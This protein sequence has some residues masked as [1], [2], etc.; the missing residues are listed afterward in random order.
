[1]AQ[2]RVLI[3]DPLTDRRR[4]LSRILTDLHYEVLEA[5]DG[6][7]G[8]KATETGNPDLIFCDN[9]IQ[10][11]SATEL[12]EYVQEF[13]AGRVPFVVLVAQVEPD[14][15]KIRQQVGANGVLRHPVARYEL[16][17]L[18]QHLLAVNELEQRLAHMQEE[19]ASLRQALAQ[20]AIIDPVTRFYRFDVF[21]QMI[22]FEV[23]RAK[24]YAYPLS[25][26]LMAFDNFD[27]VSCWLTPSQREALYTGTRRVVTACIRDIDIP[28]LFAEEKIL[29]VMPHTPLDGSAVVADRIREQIGKLRL[30]DTLAKLS[31]TVSISVA[32]TESAEVRT[33]GTLIKEAMRGLK[34]AE[35]KGGDVVL[36]CRPVDEDKKTGE[37]AEL[38]GKMGPRTFFV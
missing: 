16:A 29:I 4:E 10:G 7:V 37:C 17:S 31:L 20:K 36:V 30:P 28:L 34:E 35:I 19:N 21:K 11:H 18:G 8:L 3:I 12:C 5:A 14:P 26:L 38:G 2:Q 24:R 33:F 1:M 25:I 22:V 13:V 15:E 9:H 6:D 32:T 23:K 27:K